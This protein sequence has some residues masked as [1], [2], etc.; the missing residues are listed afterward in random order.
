MQSTVKQ[1]G[2]GPAAVVAGWPWGPCR[3][4][5]TVTQTRRGQ[6]S[7]GREPPF[8][9][10]T[11]KSPRTPAITQSHHVRPPSPAVLGPPHTRLASTRNG[12]DGGKMAHLTGKGATGGQNPHPH[13]T[14]GLS[15]WSLGKSHTCTFYHQDHIRI[16]YTLL[17]PFCS[18]FSSCLFV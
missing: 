5:E 9:R 6:R 15:S 18:E 2:R 7:P 10:G 8:S 13:G 3:Q 17:L 14:G 1:R 4:A 16:F 11:G 12:A